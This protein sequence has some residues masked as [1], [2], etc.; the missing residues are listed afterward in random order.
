[1]TLIPYRLSTNELRFDAAY[2]P[3]IVS[4]PVSM[5]SEIVK[6]ACF[7]SYC[8]SSVY[9][10]VTGGSSNWRISHSANSS[11]PCVRSPSVRDCG[12]GIASSGRYCRESGRTGV[13]PCSSYRLPRSFVGIAKASSSSGAGS[14]DPAKSAHPVPTPRFAACS[15]A[16]HARIRL[17]AS[18]A[19]NRNLRS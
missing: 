3:A 8:C 10:S 1:M 4:E 17:G 16:C 6:C 2:V 13:L 9:V 14:L 7:V 15:A 11:R 5:I 19:S 18:H 12:T